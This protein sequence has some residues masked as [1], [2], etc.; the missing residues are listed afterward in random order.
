[1]SS[2]SYKAVHALIQLGKLEPYAVS[3]AAKTVVYQGRVALFSAAR[4]A[5]STIDED[6]LALHTRLAAF[7]EDPIGT[8][9]W[10]AEPG[11]LYPANIKG[12]GPAWEHLWREARA[13][14]V[15]G[16]VNEAMMLLDAQVPWT[17]IGGEATRDYAKGKLQGL[18]ARRF[19]R[20]KLA[21]SATPN[22]AAAA[23]PI[24]PAPAAAAAPKR[25]RKPRKKTAAASAIETPVAAAAEEASAEIKH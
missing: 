9:K 20:S 12:R 8:R 1:M 15:Y 11:T 19:L 24:E 7:V 2:L 22:V 4:E 5:D 3:T 17:A 23:A 18:A 14:A 13:A 21:P 6:G 16:M 25:A 10:P